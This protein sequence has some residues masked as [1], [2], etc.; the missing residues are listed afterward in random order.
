MPRRP[1]IEERL[2]EVVELGKR[3]VPPTAAELRPYLADKAGIVAAAAAKI[4]GDAG[5]RD[6]ERELEAAFTRFLVDPVKTDPGC[7]AKLAVA[8]ALR[9]LEAHAFDV[10]LRG[11]VHR[12]PEPTFGPPID[13]AGPLRV[14]CAAALLENRHSLALLQAAPLLADKESTVRAGIA[15]VLGDIGGDACES[16]LRVRVLIG[17][18]EPQVIGAC[19]QGLLAASLDRELDFVV[20]VMRGADED[21]VRLGLLALGES[22]DE[23]ALPVLREYVQLSVDREVRAT[24]MLA[25]AIS[26]IPEA[27][28]FLEDLAANGAPARAAEARAALASLGERG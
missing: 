21:V 1:P 19:L 5:L 14:C 15:S 22:R 27:R 18:P 26:R 4:A 13:V 20:Q 24:A 11:I 16:L 8:E 2:H 25:L 9:K 23:R 10:F 12:Q 7:R 6:L 17:D 28:A 3:D